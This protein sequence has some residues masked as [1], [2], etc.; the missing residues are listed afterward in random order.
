[1]IE[2][3]FIQNTPLIPV[4]VAYG[5]SVQSPYFVLDTG[6]TGDLLVTQKIAIDLGL[7][8][9]GVT[10][11]R[12]ANGQ[13]VEVPTAIALASMEGMIKVVQVLISNSMPLAG[14]S[15]LTKFGFTASVDCRNKIIALT[16]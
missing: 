7:V 3:I 10:K 11:S 6:F 1:M 5:H 16:F 15:F 8:V 2:G 4:M 14:I 9:S 13:I 12:I